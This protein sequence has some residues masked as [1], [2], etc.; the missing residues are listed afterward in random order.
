M[1]AESNWRTQIHRLEP[2]NL[3]L[4]PC[5]AGKEHKGPIDPATGYGLNKWQQ[6]RFTV[7]QILAMNGVVRCVGTRTG[8]GRLCLDFD[9]G[10]AIELSM[11]HGCNPQEVQTWQVHRTT[12]PDRL[13]VKF[14]LTLEQQQQLGEV[15]T[16]AHTALPTNGGKGEAL[17]VFHHPGKQVLVLGEHRSSG[18]EYF[19]PDGMGPEALAPIPQNWWELVVKIAAGE[20]GIN[21]APAAKA[22]RKTTSSSGWKALNSCPICTR[23]TTRWCTT[24][25][26]NGAINCRHGSTF[27]P[28][29]RHGVLKVGDTITGA[30]GVVYGYCGDGVE[31]SGSSYSKF[32][33]HTEREK[34]AAPRPLRALPGGKA[35]KPQQ[36]PQEAAPP[37]AAPH[38]A[39][40]YRVLGWSTKLDGVWAQ[41]GEDGIVAL[42]PLSKAGLQRL[43]PIEHWQGQFPTRTG[44][45]WDRAISS[46]RDL[47]VGRGTFTLDRIRG[48]GVWLDNDRVVWHLGDRIEVD[49]RLLRLTELQD[50]AFT[51]ASLPAL[52]INP[53]VA[54]LTDA[55]GAEILKLFNESKKF[56]DNGDGL[57]AAGHTVLGNVGGALEIRPGLQLTGPTQASKSTTQDTMITPLQGGLGLYTSGSTGKGVAQ[58]MKGDALPA[59]LDESE[60]ENARQREDHLHL[61]RLSF[62]G[63]VQLKGTPGGQ[64]NSYTMRSM[65]T[66]IGINASV[67]NPADRN[68]LVIIRPRKLEGADWTQFQLTRN[69]LITIEAGRRLIRRTVSNLPALL[70]NIKTFTAVLSSQ[71]GSDRTHQVLGCLLAGAHHL[72]STAVVDANAAL[73][74]LD[75]VGWSGLDDDALEACS[76]DAEARACIDHLLAYSVQWKGS[77]TGSITVLELLQIAKAS[78]KATE[79]TSALGRLGIKWDRTHQL[80]VANSCKA[81]TSSKWG[82]GNHRDHLLSLERAQPLSTAARF[83]GWKVSKGVSVPWEVADPP[84][85]SETKQA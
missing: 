6:Q 55:E 84:E 20:L 18:G 23:D 39:A 21:P 69:K 65:I 49:G 33:V 54:P 4:L 77:E 15:A 40:K 61:L 75:A 27:S 47:A 44:T 16:K 70:A 71:K 68:R 37:A 29:L 73:A 24:R 50:S 42:V 38:P 1:N 26:D 46:V 10:T 41:T 60:Q 22:S 59:V 34:Q 72:T 45:D 2:L 12:D 8:E 82:N 52:D 30:N 3:P 56:G 51:Y 57:L 32:T 7:P 53:E 13:K 63:K 74:W 81:F 19:W 78:P 43:G 58:A 14:Q 79:A 80:V 76:A 36:P 31:S 83:P 17:E 85:E 67:T 11:A 35:T 25:P 48:R 9:G 66:L 64:P 5:G 62:D 28:L